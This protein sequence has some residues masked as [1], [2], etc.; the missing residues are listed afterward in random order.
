MGLPHKIIVRLPDTNIPKVFW[1]QEMLCEGVYVVSDS[2]MVSENIEE[3]DIQINP[4]KGKGDLGY[5]VSKVC[6]MVI[7]TAHFKKRRRP[8]IDLLCQMF[9][10]DDFEIKNKN[11]IDSDLVFSPVIDMALL[12]K[13]S[14]TLG[15][16]SN[17]E[18][19]L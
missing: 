18:K 15:D 11:I 16:M 19:L 3:F 8:K 5:K 17:L 6:D 9:I 13:E 4:S 12:I 1:A 2:K 10:G 7:I 14:N